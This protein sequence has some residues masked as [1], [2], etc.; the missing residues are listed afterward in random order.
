[1]YGFHKMS[2]SSFSKCLPMS[3]NVLL[4]CPSIILACVLQ[5]SSNVLQCPPIFSHFFAPKHEYYFFSVSSD[6]HT[7][8][9]EMP[10]HNFCLCPPMS[11]NIFP[12]FLPQNMNFI[13]F[14][15]RLMSFRVFQRSPSII[16][17]KCP[18][19]S[20]NVLPRFLPQTMKFYVLS[21]L[22]CLPMC[23]RVNPA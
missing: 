12:L 13:S 10:Q 20:T 7:C 23:F 6:V 22:R 14:L 1:M 15:C 17:S 5:I 8:L 18:P 9:S 4:R 19:M 2:F 11:S 21:I 16:P 3:S